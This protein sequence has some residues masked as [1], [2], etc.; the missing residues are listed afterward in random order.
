MRPSC[1]LLICLWIVILRNSLGKALFDELVYDTKDLSQA[2][3]N[4]IERAKGGD[5]NALNTLGTALTGR[6]MFG[7]ANFHLALE[8]FREAAAKGSASGAFNVGNAYSQGNP[9]G[10][11]K[12]SEDAFK[13]YRVAGLGGHAK[14][15]YNCG[16]LLTGELKW[17]PL[18]ALEYLRSSFLSAMR[19]NENNKNS[20][21]IEAASLAHSMM[22]EAVSKLSLSSDDLARAWRAGSLQEDFPAE[23]TVEMLWNKGLNSLRSFNQSFIA[24]KGAMTEALRDHL[25]I[26]VAAFGEIIESHASVLGALQ[27]HVVLDNLQDMIGPLAGA[28]GGESSNPRGTLQSDGKRNKFIELAARYAEAYALSPLCIKRVAKKESDPACFNG[29]ASAAMSYHRRAGDVTGAVRMFGVAAQVLDQDST[30]RFLSQTPRVYHP[31]LRAQPWWDPED[32]H[33]TKTLKEAFHKNNGLDL[34][35]QLD[36]LIKLREGD[37][38]IGGSVMEEEAIDKKNGIDTGDDGGLRRIFTPYIGVAT[39]DAI[40]EEQGAGGWSEFGPL[41][42]GIRWSEKRCKVIPILCDAIKGYLKATNYHHP[43]QSQSEICGGG[44]RGGGGGGSGGNAGIGNIGSQVSVDAAV[45]INGEVE[46]SSPSAKDIEDACG[47]DTIVTI[48]R[49]RPGTHILPHCGTTNR[50]L[51]M[52][53]ALRGADGVRFRVG[54]DSNDPHRRDFTNLEING[55]QGGWVESYGGGDGNAIVFDDSFE[56]EVKHDGKKDRF[57]LLIVLKHPDT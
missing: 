42:D 11:E 52:H 21:L 13:W 46:S 54:D 20:E 29:A 22:S 47:S 45:S 34:Q 50:R 7:D 39:D 43:L 12:S 49:L 17:D 30:W 27:G 18:S 6:S 8:F 3:I 53:F 15:L 38:R 2:Q 4:V 5:G 10:V 24:R 31:G 28:G 36:N 16:I 26:S 56:H 35:R 1:C 48:L 23:S 41:F 14:A 32:F 25:Q 19:Q 57:I 40:T 33:L 55:P 37:I 51:I 9:W 44:G